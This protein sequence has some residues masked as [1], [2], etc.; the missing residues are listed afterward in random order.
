[1]NVSIK[2][3]FCLENGNILRQVIVDYAWTELKYIVNNSF[4]KWGID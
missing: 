4:S 1:M 3:G 2:Q